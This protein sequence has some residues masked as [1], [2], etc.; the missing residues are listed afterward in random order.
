VAGGPCD[1]GT[2]VSTAAHVR[3]QHWLPPRVHGIDVLTVDGTAVVSPQGE[4]DAYEAPHLSAALNQAGL[5]GRG[6]VVDLDGVT[7]M[8]STALGVVVRAVRELGEAGRR[9]R[10]VLPR[11]AARRVFEIT[12]VDRV[13]PVAASRA[14]A[15]EELAAS[16]DT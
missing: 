10:V 1:D 13:L 2:R 7:F 5:A 4:L 14:L 8:D 6:V 3:A 9:V 12:T 15:L 16:I 11:G